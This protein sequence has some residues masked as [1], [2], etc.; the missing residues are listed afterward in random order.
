MAPRAKQSIV[1][2]SQSDETLRETTRNFLIKSQEILNSKI[3]PDHSNPLSRYYQIQINSLLHPDHDDI[4]YLL[5]VSESNTRCVKCGN[6]RKLKL[7]SN[8]RRN[9][10]WTR[11]HCRHLRCICLEHCDKCLDKRSHKLHGRQSVLDRL[12][13]VSNGTKKVRKEV[14]K[15]EATKPKATIKTPPPTVMSRF[16]N[17]IVREQ[18]HQKT[19][20]TPKQQKSRT[21]QQK[22]RQQPKQQ[23][24]T[25]QPQPKQAPQFSSRLRAFSCMLK[26]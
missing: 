10:S 15:T 25:P 2:A 14:L 17:R 18:S 6:Q 24:A 11:K 22:T 5:N 13:K 12:N 7:I 4:D 19:K 20:Y 16:D 26:E 8:R 1:V 21:P 23:T 3:Q 9:R